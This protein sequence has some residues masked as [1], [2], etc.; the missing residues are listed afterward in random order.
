MT[1]ETPI[2]I[3]VGASPV[4][5]NKLRRIPVIRYEREHCSSVLRHSDKV[6]TDCFGRASLA[7]SVSKK[8]TGDIIINPTHH[9]IR[10]GTH[11]S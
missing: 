11:P 1:P 6:E 8:S 9:Q 3:G 5:E 4:I 2:V 10:Q 7:K